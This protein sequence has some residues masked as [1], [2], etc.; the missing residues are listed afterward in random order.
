MTIQALTWSGNLL[1]IRGK[2]SDIAQQMSRQCNKAIATY[3]AS[4]DTNGNGITNKSIKAK[5][6]FWQQMKTHNARMWCTTP[7]Y[8]WTMLKKVVDSKMIFEDEDDHRNLKQLNLKDELERRRIWTQGRT[9]APV[10]QSS[11][12]L[13]LQAEHDHALPAPTNYSYRGRNQA[14]IRNDELDNE[15]HI[16]H[17]E[18]ND[19]SEVD[20]QLSDEG[21]TNLEHSWSDESDDDKKSPSDEDGTNPEYASSSDESDDG[22]NSSITRAALQ[23]IAATPIPNMNDHTFSAD[24]RVEPWQTRVK[25]FGRDGRRNEKFNGMKIRP[26]IID[27]LGEQGSTANDLVYATHDKRICESRLLDSENAPRNKHG[28]I[29]WSAKTIALYKAPRIRN[30]FLMG[31]IDPD[32][33]TAEEKTWAFDEFDRDDSRMDKD[34]HRGMPIC[35]CCGKAKHTLL[36]CDYFDERRACWKPGG[37]IHDA[38]KDKWAKQDQLST[39]TTE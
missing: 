32:D 15:E 23:N 27:A 5:M 36:N 28:F 26:M 7:E 14:R 33:L 25:L 8:M 31:E 38:Y 19:G 3:T 10:T 1:L 30:H 37:L 12:W 29:I 39:P 18:L 6:D 22:K 2:I 13:K 34:G 9:Y 11:E 4:P 20:D 17:Y 35:I 24:G 16:D 21:G